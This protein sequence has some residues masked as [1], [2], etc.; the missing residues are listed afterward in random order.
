MIKIDKAYC[1][2]TDSVLS[3]YQVRDLHFDE[4]NP[5]NAKNA[6]YECLDEDC[7]APLIGVNSTSV[8]FKNAPHYRLKRGHEHSEACD[9]N[10]ATHV[11]KAEEEPNQERDYKA[12]A[13]PNVLLLER[14]PVPRCTGKPRKP[15]APR[16]P[17]DAPI[18]L[19]TG[20]EHNSPHETSIL[21]HVVETW[22]EHGEVLRRVALT[23]GEKTKWY[24]NAFKY[25]KYFTDERGLIYWGNVK[26]IKPYGHGY[27]ITFMERPEYEGDKRQIGI[28]ITDEQ[29]NS[30]R[31]RR[32]FRRYIDSLVNSEEGTVQ[33]YFVGAYPVLKETEVVY[34]TA[35]GEQ[36][37]RPL[38][39]YLSNLDHLVLRF[40]RDEEDT[41]S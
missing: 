26:K 36:S 13:H 39:V 10:K 33:C 37:F 5:F 24:P 38:E 41:D 18:A 30:Y 29:I 12:S 31:K 3:I 9:F 35:K 7:H 19:D 25:I 11:T 23:I 17:S 28:Y 6:T 14:Q 27:S 1:H 20:R 4:D 16:D 40:N 32:L 22:L 21:E 34:Q 15:R 2:Q 8:E